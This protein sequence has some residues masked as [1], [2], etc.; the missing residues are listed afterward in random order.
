MDPTVFDCQV[1]LFTLTQLYSLGS[2]SELDFQGGKDVNFKVLIGILVNETQGPTD[3]PSGH[4]F[5]FD[6]MQYPIAI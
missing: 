2:E 1:F 5:T 3:E 6:D 4:F